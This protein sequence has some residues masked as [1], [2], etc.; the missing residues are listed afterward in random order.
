[1]ATTIGDG[2]SVVALSA[3][4]LGYYYLKHQERARRLEVLH[5]ERL[6][7]MDKG[8]PL[9]ELELDPPSANRPPDPHIPLILGMILF[10]FGAGSMIALR[11][12]QSAGLSAFW[13]IPLPVA[14]MGA[15][16]ML[17]YFLGAKQDR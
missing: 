3:A 14:L 15:G 16:L 13:P 7:A 17:Y 2:I 11:L 1:M 8:I 5:Q 12:V 9:P 10:A 4:F 6:Q